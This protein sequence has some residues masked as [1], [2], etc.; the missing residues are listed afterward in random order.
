MWR[1][2]REAVLLGAGPTALLLQL[3]HPLVAEGVAQHSAFA[4]DPARRLR[5]TLR[6]TLALVFGDGVTAEAAVRRLNRAH[7]P[8]RGATA[9]PAARAL[10]ERYRA[11]DPELLLWVQATLIWTSVQAYQRWVAP[12]SAADLEAFWREARALGTRLGIPPDRS[13]GDWPAFEAYWSAMLAVD[14]PVHV[15]ATGRRLGR[16]ILR[17][18]LPF[19][20]APLA[21]LLTLPAVDLLPDRIRAEY[22]VPWGPGRARLAAGLHAGVHL[23]VRLLP[24]V[25]RAMP[26][27]RAADRRAAG[28]T[29]STGATPGEPA[30]RYDRGPHPRRDVGRA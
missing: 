9:D 1:I 15:T 17:A 20:P 23:W 5:N 11:M 30:P 29:S 16:L 26:Q 12:L 28:R 14:G 4:A 10:A 24:P 25:W 27:A 3:A 6:T 22:D 18:P 19:L 2:D 21:A 7:A 8:V 13:P